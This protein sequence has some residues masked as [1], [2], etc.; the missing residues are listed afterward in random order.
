MEKE[1]ILFIGID[2]ATFDLMKPW[3]EDGSL[4]NLSKIARNGDMDGIPVTLME[5]MAMKLP[6]ISTTVSGIPE[7]IED[8]SSGIL[9]PPNDF[10]KLADALKFL[11]R[12]P[13]IRETMGQEGRKIIED[14]F[15]IRKT[16]VE[17]LDFF[18]SVIKS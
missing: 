2:G 5:A 8:G 11:I 3:M 6:V 1:K 17:L 16:S 10:K 12:N 4:P 9:V 18:E 7:L 14:E 15:N 13:K